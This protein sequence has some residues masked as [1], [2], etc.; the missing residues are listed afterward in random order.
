MARFAHAHHGD[1]AMTARPF[2]LALLLL[3]LPVI[4]ADPPGKGLV[5]DKATKSVTIPAM[6]APRKLPNLAEIY[7]IEVVACFPAPKGQKAHETVVTFDVK[8]S[9]VHKA[10]EGFGLKPGKPILGEGT[11]QGPEVLIFLEVPGDDG[12]PRRVP[13]EETLVEK[14]TGKTMPKV[15]WLFTGSAFK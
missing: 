5:V 11:A 13:I 12:K 3:A 2:A 14:K 9:D 15:K 4:A 6:V 8:P 7:P 1:V 10:L